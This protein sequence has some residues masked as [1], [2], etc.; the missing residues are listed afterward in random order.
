MIFAARIQ[1]ESLVWPFAETGSLSRREPAGRSFFHVPSVTPLV[2]DTS[3]LSRPR[4]K[5]HPLRRQA[6]C[7]PARCP[8]RRSTLGGE[9]TAPPFSTSPLSFRLLPCGDGSDSPFSATVLAGTAGWRHLLRPGGATLLCF[10]ATRDPPGFRSLPKRSAITCPGRTAN[11]HLL[12]LFG[13]PRKSGAWPG[14]QAPPALWCP[15]RKRGGKGEKSL[16]IR[17]VFPSL[18]SSATSHN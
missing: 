10:P 18:A 6:I 13:S 16:C 2:L 15:A 1:S 11:N 9:T 3:V 17:T 8:S 5:P 7:P 14:E 12:L 4:S